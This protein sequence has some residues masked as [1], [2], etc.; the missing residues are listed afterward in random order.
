MVAGR[1]HAVNSAKYAATGATTAP[2]ASTSRYGWNR[3]PVASRRPP[4]GTTSTGQIPRRIPIADH[5][6][7]T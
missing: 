3:S 6:Q 1:P 7:R 4:P 5:E 2:S